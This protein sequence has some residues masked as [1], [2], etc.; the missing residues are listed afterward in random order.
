M[1]GSPI[2]RRTI[3]HFAR[4]AVLLSSERYHTA[5]P[6]IDQA[7]SPALLLAGLFAIIGRAGH[8][9]AGPAPVLFEITGW[10]EP[11]PKNWM[12]L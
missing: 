6:A 2:T 3:E 11:D 10:I 5:P 9:R 1:P 4:F 7:N 12:Y 8:G